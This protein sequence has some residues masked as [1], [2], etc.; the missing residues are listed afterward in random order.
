MGLDILSPK[1]PP[2]LG[3]DIGASAIK[4]VELSR[5][6]KGLRLE[7]Y[8]VEPVTEPL[9]V[10]DGSV[11]DQEGLTAA[12]QACYR[13][14]GS[15]IKGA[16]AA[17]PSSMIVTKTLRVPQGLQELEVEE[18][19][20]VE[21]ATHIAFPIDEAS[22]DYRVLPRDDSAEDIPVL[23]AVAVRARVEERSNAIEAAGLK[24]L[25]MDSELLALVDATS[26]FMQRVGI[27]YQDRNVLVVDIGSSTTHFTFLR[28][29]EVVYSREHHFGGRQ[30]TRDLHEQ[31]GVSEDD[32]RRIK[33]GTKPAPDEALAQQLIEA[34]YDSAAHEAK[35][36]VQIFTTST[37]FASVDSVLLCGTSVTSGGI[38]RHVT[39]V[40]GVPARMLNPF[41]G[42]RLPP[43]IDE[44]RLMREGPSLVVA[45]GLAMRRFDK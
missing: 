33:A 4:M 17:L 26:T 1:A 40:L 42:M 34:F 10:D 39:E 32:A 28:N 45:F 2:V 35:R 38:C 43:N 19:V 3:V 12:I 44:A 21:M 29:A 13:R 9:F 37:N 23:A 16:A 36:A 25:I 22:L 5:D 14:L 41:E 20:G 27:D 7:K 24:P 6:K 30:L 15:K 31:L 18:Q 11:S 8:A